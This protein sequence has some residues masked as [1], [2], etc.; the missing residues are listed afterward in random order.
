MS[1][2]APKIAR[3]PVSAATLATTQDFI[4]L[5]PGWRLRVV[6]PKLKSAGYQLQTGDESLAADGTG[7]LSVT[8]SAGADFLGYEIAYYAVTESRG[9]LH[10]SFTSAN[11]LQDG[12][13]T[14]RATPLELLFQLAETAK[15]IRLIYLVR[16]SKADHNL[17]VAAASQQ[18]ELSALTQ[19]VQ[20][21][22]AACRDAPYASCQWVPAGI[23]VSPERPARV[24]GKLVWLA[25]P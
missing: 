6:T 25:A 24:H 22:P 5:Q 4:D 13:T 12:N 10:V 7:K 16:A 17:A 18:D 19:Q 15:Y 2:C 9:A 11:L 8:L 23:A 1:G 20:T 3:A 14:P 21:N